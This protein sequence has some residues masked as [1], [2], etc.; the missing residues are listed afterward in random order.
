MGGPGAPGGPVLGVPGKT[1]NGGTGGFWDRSF[2][3]KKRKK[4]FP[5]NGGTWK[6]RKKLKKRDAWDGVRI[7]GS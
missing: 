3:Q 1:E 7:E 2:F 5:E 6:K 4:S